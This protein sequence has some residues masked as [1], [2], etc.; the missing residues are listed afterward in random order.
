MGHWI[1]ELT[2]LLGTVG[3][4]FGPHHTANQNTSDVPAAR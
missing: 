2:G 1:L 4:L 3:T